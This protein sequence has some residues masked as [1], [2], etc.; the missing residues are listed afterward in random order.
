[1]NRRVGAARRGVRSI[2]TRFDR[3]ISGRFI[4]ATRLGAP[5]RCLPVLYASYKGCERGGLRVAAAALRVRDRSFRVNGSERGGGRR[6]DWPILLVIA[7]RS[8]SR[9]VGKLIR[10]WSWNLC[11][12]DV[13]YAYTMRSN[14]VA[15]TA[16][17]R[18]PY[19][20]REWPAI[21][22]RYFL[23]FPCV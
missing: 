11:D 23:D 13:D 18:R 15:I 4:K 3:D 8:Q 16:S 2:S 6:S 10:F 21:R 20:H 17:L 22:N 9:L 7:C 5:S 1:M 19:R 14:N 12:S